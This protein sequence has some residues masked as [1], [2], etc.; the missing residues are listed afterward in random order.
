MLHCQ[1]FNPVYADEVEK[2][3]NIAKI[4]CQM[5]LQQIMI[6]FSKIFLMIYK[7]FYGTGQTSIFTVARCEIYKIHGS[8][9][10]QNPLSLTQ[11]RLSRGY[12]DK[13]K[14]LAAKLMTFLW[15]IDYFHKV[16]LFQIQ[17]FRRF[18]AMLWNVCH[19][20][21]INFTKRFILLNIIRISLEVR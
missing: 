16:T 15:N 14:Y 9:Q 5:W 11:S 10:N 1:Q 4:I 3:R 19:W 7:T 8:V 17:I 18:L 2:L 12:T 20:I 13:G 21:K 6:A